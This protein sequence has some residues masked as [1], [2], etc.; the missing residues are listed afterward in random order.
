MVDS[1]M[2]GKT[3]QGEEHTEKGEAPQMVK[4]SSICED[5]YLNPCPVQV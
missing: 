5:T 2:A 3:Q 1:Q 4:R